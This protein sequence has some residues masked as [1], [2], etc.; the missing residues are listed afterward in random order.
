MFFSQPA[1]VKQS[2]S[3]KKEYPLLSKIF[4][5]TMASDL[6]T[7]SKETKER[8]CAHSSL[9][10]TFC[11][12]PE[13][14][15]EEALSEE[16]LSFLITEYFDALRFD[17]ASRRPR[18]D[19]EKIKIGDD[20]LLDI[21][22][23]TSKGLLPFSFHEKRNIYLQEETLFPTFGLI[24]EG[25]TVG[26]TTTIET[27]LPSH[28]VVEE[29]RQQEAVFVVH[30]LEAYEV[31][32]PSHDDPAFLASLALGDSLEEC[33]AA[34]GKQLL[35]VEN[36]RIQNQYAYSVFNTL[37]AKTSSPVSDEQ[38]DQY[39]HELWKRK[40]GDALEK[41]GLPQQ[42]INESLLGWLN[43]APLREK[44][45]HEIQTTLLFLDLAQFFRI[46]L[47]EEEIL[48]QMAPFLEE[49]NLSLLEQSSKEDQESI[50]EIAWLILQ[51]KTLTALFEAHLPQ[52]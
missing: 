38:I 31:S 16:K 28:Y 37:L 44:A 51:Q 21:V 36:T 1:H 29:L 14:N 24:L 35:E 10:Q 4:A 47:S 42:D 15:L 50:Q 2:S 26:E 45:Q 41:K 40:E 34:L 12:P 18:K 3:S 33:L 23:Y 43:H 11:L 52:G 46:S 5:S 39:L 25:M 13:P 19:G 7:Q 49:T 8:L 32:L 27:T 30:I 22:G 9:L 6:S 20:I 17:A 48:S